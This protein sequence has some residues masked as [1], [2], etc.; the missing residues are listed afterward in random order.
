MNGMSYLLGISRHGGLDHRLYSVLNPFRRAKI[1][2]H[3]FINAFTSGSWTLVESGPVWC[4][5]S[6]MELYISISGS[7]TCLVWKFHLG[8]FF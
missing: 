6:L 7:G 8:A 5:L 1:C 4:V 2:F 3:L